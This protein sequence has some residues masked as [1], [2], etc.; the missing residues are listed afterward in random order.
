MLLG[1]I[2]VEGQETLSLE[3]CRQRALSAN[4]GLK[5]AS[6]KRE[7]TEALE[8]VALWQMLPKV[9]ANGAY[10]WTE[11]SVNLL[12]EEQKDRISHM[13]D[14]LQADINQALHNELSGLNIGPVNIGDNLAD[15]LSN[16]FSTSGLSDRV[17][18]I[19]G[20]IVDGLNTDTRNMSLATVTLTQPVYMGG[21]LVAAY[22]TSRLLN[23]LSGI[24]YDK[25]REET[26]IAV[27][28]AYWTV[29]SVKYKK[30][31]AEKYAALLDTLEHNV[32]L[33]VDAEMATKGDLAKVRVKR[34]EAQMS[35]TKATNGLVL[36][37]MLSV[38]SLQS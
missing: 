15:R 23:H 17:N 12:S 6:V 37:K 38:F 22:R 20:E 8:K 16:V 21:K 27:D 18:D 28:E 14:N 5:Q 25:K 24:E 11:K 31:L 9:S 2:S 32:E 33:A 30:E 4:R 10:T 7:Q 13:G 26:L 35:L 19:G 1:S 34:N 36:A 29:I 3:E